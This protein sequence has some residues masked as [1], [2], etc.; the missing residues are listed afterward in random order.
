MI[1]IK[2]T[3]IRDAAT[4]QQLSSRK[5]NMIRAEQLA[6]QEDGIALM[7]FTDQP[8]INEDPAAIELPKPLERLCRRA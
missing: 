6:Q 2:P 4:M 1:F 8:V 5:Y 3:I 7:P